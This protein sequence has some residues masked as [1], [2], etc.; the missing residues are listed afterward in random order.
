MGSV[1]KKAASSNDIISF[2]RKFKLFF[3]RLKILVDYCIWVEKETFGR[4]SREN[5]VTS[6]W[7]NI[8]ANY[9]CVGLE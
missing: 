3:G 1:G 6:K 5:L 4:H 2:E 8:M 9:S 7:S